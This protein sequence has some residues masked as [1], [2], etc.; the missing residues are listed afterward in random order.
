MEVLSVD[1]AAALNLL[2]SGEN[3]FVTGGAG[4]GKSFLIRRYLQELNPEKFPILA[5]TG[6][7]AVLL[8]GRTFHSFF[9]LGIMDG[10][11]GAT[12]E[13]AQR[14]SRLIAR[15]R[16]IEGIILDEVS[17]I[18]GEALRVAETLARFARDSVSAWGGLRVVVVGD[19]AQLPPVTRFGQAR[20][21]CFQTTTWERSGFHIAILSHNQ[22]TAEHEYLN[23]LGDIRNGE[24]SRR[25]KDFLDQHS[26]GDFVDS[27]HE[28]ESE[29][30]TTRLLPRRNQVEQ[31]NLRRL[32]EI[33]AHEIRID[34]IYLGA[35]RF[36]QILMKAA[37]VPQQL[38][39][40]SGCKV[41]MIQNDPKKRWVN[42]TIGL[43]EDISQEKLIVRK[44]DGRVVPIEK[45]SFAMQD[46]DGNVVASVIQ[47][48]VI[49]AYATTI[50]KSQG[51]TLDSLW[52]DLSNLWEPG[53]AYVALSRLRSEKGLRLMRWNP[54]SIIVDP[55]VKN[56]YNSL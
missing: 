55:A 26:L 6:A 13:R 18:P 29:G 27:D 32:S 33:P 8:G 16:K 3:V 41:M 40:K 21:W 20:D 19:F 43:L 45:S 35:E 24:V 30:F 25:V 46:A 15:L 23:V 39:L 9:G 31:Y 50:H 2:K 5:S 47:F 37:P 56:F 48:P 49:L 52:C 53:Q 14:D 22:R 42:G 10:G 28:C 44:S 1:Q 54:R 11:S 7:A 17:M 38:I 12:L 36:V 4:S 51:A 34:S